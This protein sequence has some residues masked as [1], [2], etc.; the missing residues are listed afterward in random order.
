MEPRA[1]SEGT[2]AM[3]DTRMHQHHTRWTK[4]WPI[5]SLNDKSEHRQKKVKAAATSTPLPNPKQSNNHQHQ[6][7][8]LYYCVYSI[9]PINYT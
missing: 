7:K 2:L 9:L 3:E 1:E 5:A 4:D 6:S 8:L